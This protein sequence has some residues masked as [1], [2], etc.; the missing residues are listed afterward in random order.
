MKKNTGILV[1]LLTLAGSTYAQAQ[2]SQITL[3]LDQCIALALENQPALRQSV[4]QEKIAAN[5]VEQTRRSALPTLAGVTN[6]GL[7]FGRNVDPYTNGITNA[8]ITTNN[9][10]LSANWTLFNGFQLKNIL[11]QQ[12]L[13]AQASKLD[14][15]A[16]KNAITLN[17]LLSYMQVLLARDLLTVSEEQAEMART[18]IARTEKLVKAGVIAPYNLH[19]A[20]SQL[21]N[22]EMQRVQAQTNLKSA[23]LTLLQTLNLPASTDIQ[24][25][26]LAGELP[27]PS[28]DA[29]AH[30]L[31][32]QARMFMP[33]VLAADLRTKAARKGLDLAK[34]VGYPVVTLAASWGTSYSSAARRTTFGSELVEQTTPGFV[35]V[36][37]EAYPVRIVTSATSEARIGYFRQLN[38]NQYK[39]VGLNIRIPIVN[40]F[41]VKYRTTHARLQQQIAESQAE[42]VRRELRQNIDQAVNQWQNARDRHQAFTQQAASLRQSFRATAARYEAGQLNA[43]DYNLAKSGLDRALV[44][45]IQAQYETLLR[46]KVVGFYREGR[47]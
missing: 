2:T 34:G 41:Q 6:Q 24:V 14:V 33:E 38:N 1:V 26:R 37:G 5:T 39:S 3:S 47:L 20:K 23:T 16:A 8:Q 42:G 10:G 19:D 9:A 21:A 35:E 46:A 32:D 30:Q 13:T 27:M 28:G 11:E 36:A 40:G 29:D 4:L 22:D 17:A 44:G 43:T 18:Q 45:E 12:R 25:T 15:A 31:Y 7:N